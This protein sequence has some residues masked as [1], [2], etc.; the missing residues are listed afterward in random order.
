[1]LTSALAGC[2]GTDTTDLEQQI[3]ELQQ[4]NDEMNETI[5]IMGI[6][7]QERNTEIS[8]LIS[9]VAMLQSSIIETET[10]RDSLLVLLENS[11]TSADELESMIEA[12]NITILTLQTGLIVQQNLV[13]Q[14]QQTV[15]NDSANLSNASLI[16]A[17]LS[18]VSLIFADLSNA[19]L[20]NAD[21]SGA[22]LS[23]ADLSNA[24]LSNASLSGADLSY[25][26]LSNAHLSGADLS[27]ADLTGINWYSTTC[28]DGYNTESSE[29]CENH[30]VQFSDWLFIGDSDIEGW[31]TS[32]Y[33]DSSNIG[34]G[35]YMCSDVLSS[36]D[37][38]LEQYTPV[39]V[40]IV[41]GENDLWERTVEDTFEDFQSIVN[42]I[43]L[44]GASVTY[45][46]TKAEPGT[47]ELHAEYRDYD[48]RIQNSAV[49]LANNSY[50][51]LNVVDVYQG[52][53]DMGNPNSLYQED[54]LHLSLD[55]YEYWNQ[56]LIQI[57]NDSDCI[58]WQSQECRIST[59]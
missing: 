2:A 25:T 7:L 39:H 30:L 48:S 3:V 36:I 17:D 26:N 55:G 54:E 35:G 9:N 4:S 27:G 14:W 57:S 18:N 23:Y 15:E 28:P 50:V 1:M 24:D 42:K 19:D 46:G 31:D 44:S 43:V 40:V 22:D 20:S 6:T 5:Y 37:E 53:E 13:A 34:V 10:Y 41:C 49:N 12:V 47:T 52:F 8:T 56:W 11:N 33:T 51:P 29:T 21:L 38:V 16:F 59:E 32:R 45:M 58:I